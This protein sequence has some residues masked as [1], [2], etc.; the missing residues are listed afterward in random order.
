MNMLV[1]NVAIGIKRVM[2]VMVDVTNGITLLISTF[3]MKTI[4]QSVGQNLC[5]GLQHMGEKDVG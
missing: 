1:M 4:R 5:D 2:E 3:A